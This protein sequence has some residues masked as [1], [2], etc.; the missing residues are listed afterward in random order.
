MWV[1]LKLKQRQPLSDKMVSVQAT[2]EQKERMLPYGTKFST[3]QMDVQVPHRSAAVD[4]TE[5]QR[6]A[7]HGILEREECHD[8]LRE[9]RKL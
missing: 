6:V 1:R 5:V 9:T 8:D 3:Q 4:P 7:D 2:K